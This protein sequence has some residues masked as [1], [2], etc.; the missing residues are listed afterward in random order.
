VHDRALDAER[1]HERGEEAR[2]RA[3]ACGAHA[4]RD[5]AAEAG[6]VHGDDL[7]VLTERR[8]DLEPVR[9]AAAEAVDEQVRDVRATV[10]RSQAPADRVDLRA[11]HVDEAERSDAHAALRARG[12][13]AD[14]DAH[15]G[16]FTLPFVP[17]APF[18]PFAPLLSVAS[19]V[20][21]PLGRRGV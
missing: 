7:A 8:H 18:E 12:R 14:P 1:V 4:R 21:M 19:H 20:V 15:D 11:A 10:L 16:P 13:R 9:R 3:H 17:F 5:G 2:V 6:Q